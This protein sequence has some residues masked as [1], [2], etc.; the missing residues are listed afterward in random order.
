[1][2]QNLAKHFLP[3]IIAVLVF[4]VVSNTFLSMVNKDYG[5]KQGD[6]EKVMGMSKELRDYRFLNNEEALWTNN[7]FCGMP[8]YQ[9]NMYFASNWVSRFDRI[10]KFGMDPAIGSIYMCMLGF[11]ILLM[12]LRVNPWLAIAISISFGLS[13]INLMYLGG[14]HTSKVNAISYM[15]PV[16]GGMLVALRGRALLGSA[17]FALFLALH[18]ASN[19]FQMTYYLMFLLFAVGIAE[20][21]RALVKREWKALLMGVGLLLI[22]GVLAALPNAG[23]LMLTNEYSKFTTRGETDLTI[24]P[25]NDRFTQAKSGLDPDYIVMYNMG[26]GDLWAMLI[27]NAQGGISMRGESMYSLADNKEAMQQIPKETRKAMTSFPQYWG[28]QAITTGAFYF[29]AGMMLLFLLGILFSQ[30]N[31]RW[32]FLALFVL[33]AAL[34]LKST[35][36][37]NGLFINHFPLYNKFRDTKMILVLVQLMVPLMGAVFLNELIHKNFHKRFMTKLSAGVIAVILVVLSLSLNPSMLGSMITERESESM[38]QYK[39]DK[40]PRQRDFIFD[41]ENAIV[42]ARE[43][44]FRQDAN[45]TVMIILVVGGLAVLIYSKK[46]KAQWVMP[47]FMVVVV[48]DMWSV[49]RRYMNDEKSRD[50]EGNLN[51]IY[52]SKNDDRWFPF[53]ESVADQFILNKESINAK[54]FDVHRQQLITAMKSTSYMGGLKTDRI[55]IAAK[56][57]ALQ[58]GTNYRV[59]RLQALDSDAA[60]AYFHKTLGGYHAAKLKRYQQLVDFYLSDQLQAVAGSFK[61]GRAKVDSTL[62]SVQVIN[63]LNA[64]Y[65]IFNPA[66]PPV[67]NSANAFGN[68]WFV[69]SLAWAQNSDEEMMGLGKFNLKKVAVVHDEFKTICKGATPCDSSASVKMTNYATKK[70]HYHSSNS[71]EGL[72]VFSETYYPAGWKCRIDGNEVESFRANYV[73]RAVNVPAGEHDIEWSF[74]PEIYAQTNLVNYAG[75]ISLLGFSLSVLIAAIISAIRKQKLA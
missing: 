31:L 15:A 23:N 70:I 35:S 28:T 71:N 12:C 50:S 36:G 58:L 65:V 69:D 42:E 68:A 39:N 13:T 1:M 30:D 51:Y 22:G 38:E 72:V 55:E 45:R 41:V 26:I 59:L 53:S 43:F 62:K 4:V 75:S 17:V 67:D 33:C 47:V 52:Y 3:H 44:V 74:E 37:L 8:G 20:G 40:D 56:Y 66:S 73:L 6:I 48:A 11:Y 25:E 29:G 14:G 9:I 19:H 7:M 2:W 63:M 49:S 32:P 18:L 21:I 46:V 61:G 64:K 5:L 57:G 27:P 24:E 54:D 10:I 16:L 34:S 60:T